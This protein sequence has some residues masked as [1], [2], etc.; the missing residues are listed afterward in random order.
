M[1]YLFLLLFLT[2]NVFS[3]N[4]H[5]AVDK[6][7]EKA[8]P[9]TTAP[10]SPI[11][12]VANN[13][14]QNSATLNWT[15]ATDDVG[16]VLYRVYNNGIFLN[17]TEDPVT[18]YSLNG[19]SPNTE[20]NITI[21]AVDASSNESTDSNP[22][23][24]S[25]LKINSSENQP[26]EIA[27]FDAY[28]LPVSQKAN[29]QT[30]LDTYGAVRLEAGNYSGTA[31]TMTS[32]QRLYGHPS[33]T[34]AP[35]ITIIAG[36]TNVHIEQIQTDIINFQSGGIISNS[37]FKSI[38]WAN[39]KTT[40]GM[41]EDN[42]FVDIRCQINFDCSTS[43]YF[44]NNTFI[45]QWVHGTYPQT[46][47][48]GNTATPSYGNVQIWINHLTPE[49]DPTEYNN[50]ASSTII[51]LDSEAWNFRGLGNKAMLYMRNMG[52]VKIT[53][54]GGGNHYAALK[55]PAFDIQAT[56]LSFFNKHIGTAS[57]PSTAQA[58]TNVFFVSG[59]N[60][61]YILG[62][63][64]TGFDFRAHFNSENITY[65][66]NQITSTITSLIG[67]QNNNT[68]IKNSILGT[69]RTPFARPTHNIL[70]N[71][72]GNDWKTN[73]EGQIDQAS[74]IQN[75]IDTNGIAELPEGT[76][77]IG[78]TLKI[79]G[80]KG[81]IGAG[82]GKTAIVGLNDN[83]PLITANFQG[84]DKI[85][86]SNLTLQGGST[87]L[88]MANTTFQASECTF[89]FLIFRDQKYGIHLDRI[90]GLDNNFFDNVSFVNCNIGFYQQ[91]EN[92]EDN[93]A[94]VDKVVF[95]KTQAINCE[96]GF[97]MKAT[98]ADNLNAW[99]D[100]KFDGNG[101]AA[102]ISNNNSPI[103]TNCEFTNHTGNVVIEG[104]PASYFSCNFSNNSVN[105]I[106]NTKGG[107]FEGCNFSDNVTLF[108]DKLHY[109]VESYIVNSTVR[110]NLG[111]ITKGM[112]INSAIT[113]N[114]DLSKL[115]INIQNP[116]IRGNFGKTTVLID[117]EA[118]PYPQYLVK[119]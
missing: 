97:S 92:S 119:Y 105:Y 83:F 48:K 17:S 65:K 54:F 88:L 60:D 67:L 35:Q 15:A 70:P 76:Y 61:D 21:R 29:L 16:V 53:D 4:Y 69:K 50:L 45:K 46:I 95:Y 56:N 109:D 30:A 110:G 25:T 89:K 114:P 27:Y 7:S 117:D 68:K 79:S 33:I 38:K 22:L 85:I 11:N 90:F 111:R 20:Y 113:S 44:R 100:C 73:R 8:S 87:G 93:W 72:T 84:T 102:S 118:T 1:R 98:R 101:Q 82:T 39:L 78:S 42:T 26:E 81:I 66:V 80:K 63:G 55:T 52:D 37:T 12:L 64:S 2:T 86:L 99:I 41:L 14:T 104:D 103:F 10:T 57:G 51:G 3:Q 40:N 5:Y 9:D 96:M 31:I 36:S 23:V 71:P 115:L 91:S 59:V 74:Y 112:L 107:R 47:M 24:F 19:L 6:A 49:G 28:L 116:T 18:S 108:S 62:N 77:Y 43:G 13:I 106:F 34:I 58:N 75:L 94:Y 32:N